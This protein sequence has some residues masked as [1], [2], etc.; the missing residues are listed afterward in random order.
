[1]GHG[2]IVTERLGSLS[3]LFNFSYSGIEYL[4]LSWWCSWS[5]KSK[6]REGKFVPG[7]SFLLQ[8]GQNP[9][10][11]L[12]WTCTEE[13]FLFFCYFSLFLVLWDSYLVQK[14]IEMCVLL[15]GIVF[16]SYF[17]YVLKNILSGIHFSFF[18]VE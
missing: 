6:E 16:S 11:F 13:K 15:D 8:R 5:L 1:M 4:R 9:I 14:N 7:I 2:G 18:H 10:F 17:C 12:F 3:N